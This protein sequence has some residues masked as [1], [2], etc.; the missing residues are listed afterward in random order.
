MGRKLD[1]K[2]Q[3]MPTYA[4]PYA[5]GTPI[6]SQVPTAH[7]KPTTHPKINTQHPH[8]R[9]AHTF[10]KATVQ[11]HLHHSWPYFLYGQSNTTNSTSLPPSSR[12]CC[13]QI[14]S[15]SPPHQMTPPH[16]R[17]PATPM[18][19]RGRGQRSYAMGDTPTYTLVPSTCPY[20]RS[21]AEYATPNRKQ[22]NQVK[23]QWKD[24]P[25]AVGTPPSLGIFSFF[26]LFFSRYLHTK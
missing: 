10:F 15:G 14:S 24:S 19:A 2:G 25:P 7:R 20:A 12:P 13:Q 4:P 16:N 6:L 9:T 8:G 5:S 11:H 21:L 26:C 1:R 17:P 3:T 18:E 22:H 23:C